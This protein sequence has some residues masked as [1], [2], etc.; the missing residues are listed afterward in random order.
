METNLGILLADHVEHIRHMDLNLLARQG[1]TTVE[2]QMAAWHAPWR[3][4]SLLYYLPFGWS[5]GV[6]AS[7]QKP[8]PSPSSVKEPDPLLL[9]YFLAQPVAFF[10]GF[11]QTLWVEHIQ[12]DSSVVRDLL[13]DAVFRAAREKHFQRVFFRDPSPIMDALP[14]FRSEIF[15]SAEATFVILHTT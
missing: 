7:Q 15:K 4:E 9:G 5:W 11:T 12:F 8:I 14:Q 3:E 1:K 13:L 10:R 2:D 6:W